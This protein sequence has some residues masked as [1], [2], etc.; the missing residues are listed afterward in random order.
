MHVCLNRSPMSRV[1]ELLINHHDYIRW[2]IPDR[3]S[4]FSVPGG[5]IYLNLKESHMMLAR[6]LGLY[7]P[8]KT[9]AI[10]TLVRAGDTFIDVGG[11]KGDFALLAAKIVGDDGKVI[12]IEPEPSNVDWIRRS[13]GLNGYRNVKVCKL[14]LS[15]HDGESFLHLGKKSG[16][17]TL[18]SGAP[19]RNQGSINVRV[20]RLDG[21]LSELEVRRVDFLKIDVEGAELE[22]LKGA[23][24]TLRSNPKIVLFLDIHPFLGVNVSRVF[25]Y[26]QGLGLAVCRVQSPYNMPATPT[27]DIG[28]V[29]AR[30]L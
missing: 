25:D 15:D 2:M 10:Q 22:V 26:L 20:R 3:H 9:Q 21:L 17:H 14:A 7:E 24:E 12:C 4:I 29:V 18:L 6:S 19:D 28:D 13:I 23:A 1:K 8:A 5:R 30:R 16:F 11:N 27:S